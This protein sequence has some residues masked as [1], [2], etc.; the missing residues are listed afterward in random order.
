MPA[1]SPTLVVMAAGMASRYRGLVNTLPANG[2]RIRIPWA[3]EG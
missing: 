3:V 1:M 2:L